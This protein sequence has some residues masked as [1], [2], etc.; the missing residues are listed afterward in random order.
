MVRRLPHPVDNYYRTKWLYASFEVF[1]KVW[2]LQGHW[3]LQD[4]DHMFLRNT[5]NHLPNDEAL[6]FQNTGTLQHLPQE[7]QFQILMAFISYM[8]RVLLQ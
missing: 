8:T 3:S 6:K 5:R 1:T 4:K 7:V 2:F